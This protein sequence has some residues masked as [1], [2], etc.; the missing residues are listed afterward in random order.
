MRATPVAVGLCL[1]ALALCP[2][3]ALR[4]QDAPGNVD[5]NVDV[6]MDVDVDV[7]TLRARGTSAW[8]NYVWS[9]QKPR[10]A[11][12]VAELERARALSDGRASFT[13]V[14]V[15][16]FGHLVL[17]DAEP[18][19]RALAELRE[20]APDYGPLLLLDGFAA[21]LERD[22]KAALARL[23]AFVDAVESTPPDPAFG[24]EFRFLAYLH[25]GAQRYDMNMHDAAASDLRTAVRI[26]REND[27]EPPSNLVMRLALAHQMLSEM[28][29][30]ERLVRGMLERDPRNAELYYNLGLLEGTQKRLPEARSWYEFALARNPRHASAHGKLAF[31]TWRDVPTE[32][33]ALPR[34]RGELEAYREL[35]RD[36]G[37][38]QTTADVESGFGTYWLAIARKRIELGLG[39]AAER[40]YARAVRHFERALEHEPGCVRALNSIIQAG[41]ELEW[42]EERLAPYRARYGEILERAPDA[43]GAHRSSFC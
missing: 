18:G 14:Y 39:D 17:G 3:A 13:Q 43:P 24:A 20:R 34:M 2:G 8:R 35:A 38:P 25:R 4:A 7:D 41:A 23:D 27:R 30:A 6:N 37:T 28:G 33:Q 15:I 36:R 31:L 16:A 40:A 1:I 22:G 10:L 26:A 42:P 32:P 19:R 9:M 21:I 12:A 29:A 11:H 5:V